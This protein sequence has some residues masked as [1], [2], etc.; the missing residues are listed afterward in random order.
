MMAAQQ[1]GM[2]NRC[3]FKWLALAS[4]IVIW[5]NLNLAHAQ[6]WQV[7]SQEWTSADEEGYS[8]FVQAIGESGC[9]TPSSCINS[10]ANPLRSGDEWLNF[11]A[12]CADLIYLLRAYYA[13]KHSLP[14]TF[15]TAVTSRGRGDI[16]F[17]SKGN[18]IVGRRTITSG[19]NPRAVF[20]TLKDT[21]SSA[22]FRVGPGADENELSD[23]YPVKIQRGSVRPGTAIYDVNGHVAIVYKV[24]KDG[25]IHYMDAHPDFTLSR[26]VYGAQFGRDFPEMGAG[27]KNFRPFQVEGGRVRLAANHQIPDYSTEQFYGNVNPDPNRDWR[28]AQ[29]RFEGTTIGYYE[30]VRLAMADGRLTFDPVVELRET[31]KTLCNDLYDRQ[32][33]VEQAIAKGI[34]R[35]QHPSRLPANIYGSDNMEWEIYSTPSRDARLKAAFRAMRV[36]LVRLIEL[37]NAKDPRINYGGLNLQSDLKEQ[38]HYSAERCIVVYRNSAGRVITMKLPEVTQRLFKL[39]FNPY[40]CV[41][42]RWGATSSE[43]LASCANTATEERWYHAQQGLRNQIDRD[44]DARM[45]F[46]VQ[47]LEAGGAGTGPSTQANVDI[48][49]VIDG[50]RMR[51]VR[52]RWRA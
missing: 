35:K 4:A 20:E 40:D 22:M 16:R 12:D 43:E 34:D 51:P 1:I 50:T 8:T 3:G 19:A 17:S 15:A 48:L 31:I 25:R 47:E 33:Y 28:Q 9:N 39:S 27:F 30:Y 46:T 7:R 45:D 18:R 14:F 6:A 26:S 23:F 21:V 44:Y 29:F 5:G 13:W 11:D 52:S 32:R 38:Y 37:Y 42:R 24:G 2:V 10:D 41:E 49:S 36:D